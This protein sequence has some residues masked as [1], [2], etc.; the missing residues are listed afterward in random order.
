MLIFEKT[1]TMFT[2]LLKCEYYENVIIMTR[3]EQV[4]HKRLIL[5][6]KDNILKDRNT[7]WVIKYGKVHAWGKFQRS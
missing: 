3:S 5:E 6:L 7:R 1:L 4:E 2:L